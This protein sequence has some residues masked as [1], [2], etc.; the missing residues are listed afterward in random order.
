MAIT[1]YINR[2]VIL[3]C[4]NSNHKNIAYFVRFEEKYSFAQVFSLFLLAHD[5]QCEKLKETF[6]L[7]CINL[8][9]IGHHCFRYTREGVSLF[10]L[11]QYS[12]HIGSKISKEVIV[13]L[14]DF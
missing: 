9:Q 3:W 5:I 13:L 8:L 1:Q 10:S 6:D 7:K 12:W 4:E 2:K 14:S 11:L